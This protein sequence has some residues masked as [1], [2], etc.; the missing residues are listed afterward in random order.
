M[1]EVVQVAFLN[2][3]RGHALALE[4]DTQLEI[5]HLVDEAAGLAYHVQ[6]IILCFDL[7]PLL[8]RHEA[9]M[10]VLQET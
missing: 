4:A 9:P 8:L 6:L 1:H 5:A 10:N 3:F 7:S 2:L